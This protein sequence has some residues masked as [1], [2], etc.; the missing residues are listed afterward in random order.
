[1]RDLRNF[2]R[3]VE[4]TAAVGISFGLLVW[5]R[6]KGVGGLGEE[7]GMSVNFALLC[8][9]FSFTMHNLIFSCYAVR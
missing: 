1:M 9:N 4:V 5:Y 7:K 8:R 2:L 3:R 6:S